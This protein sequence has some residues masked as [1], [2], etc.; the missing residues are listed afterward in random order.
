VDICDF[1]L[2]GFGLECAALS[3]EPTAT[4]LTHSLPAARARNVLTSVRQEVKTYL[5]I[6]VIP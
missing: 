6:G 1:I 5:V 4:P 2:K 3:F